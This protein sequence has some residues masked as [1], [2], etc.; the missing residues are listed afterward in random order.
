MKRAFSI[1]TLATLLLLTGCATHSTFEARALDA[2]TAVT[3]LGE[4]TS[5]VLN[6]AQITSAEATVVRD[7]LRPAHDALGL[8]EEAYDGNDVATAE[9]R[10]A[11][12]ETLLR[13]VRD[14]LAKAQE[15]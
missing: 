11:L 4:T 10:L 15:K 2:E 3:V 9:G 5:A 12:V 8:A 7:V 14:R 13:G 1:F 6:V